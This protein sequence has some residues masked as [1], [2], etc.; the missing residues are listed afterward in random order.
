M[1]DHLEHRLIAAARRRWV[2]CVAVLYTI[3][4]LWIGLVPFDFVIRGPGH[5]PAEWWGLAIA[6]AHAFDLAA[7][8]ALYIPVGLLLRALWR[9][10]V[11]RRIGDLAAAILLG[12]T[13]T[14]ATEW[15][16]RFSP[17][18]VGSV[19]DFACNTVG[20]GVGALLYSLVGLLSFA[21]RRNLRSM[22]RRWSA[23]ILERP[24][25]VAAK[26]LAAIIFLTAMVPFDVTISVNRL[27]QS[28]QSTCWHPFERDA[29]I[30]RVVYEQK[31]PPGV[32]VPPRIRLNRLR[33]KQQLQ[34]DY[35]RL[36][37]AYCLL[38]GLLSV[39]LYRHCAMTGGRAA[40][41]SVWSATLLAM[42]CFAG[43]WVVMSRSSDVTEILLAIIGSSVGTVAGA[44][45]ARRPT[46]NHAK[47]A[48]P[49]S[50]PPDG[51][52]RP[53]T[54][55]WLGAAIA[56]CA[57][58]AIARETVPLTATGWSAD[59]PASPASVEWLPLSGYQ[60]TKL[61]I[62]VHD[63][64]GKLTG[65]ALIFGLWTVRRNVID[66]CGRA[67]RPLRVAAVAMITVAGL[68]ALQLV[69]PTRTPSVTDVLI[70]GAAAATGVMVA[71]V[72]RAAIALI[73]ADR[74]QRGESVLFNVAFS[75]QAPKEPAAA[76]PRRPESSEPPR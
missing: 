66:P 55:R 30:S 58:F 43:Q 64:F 14:Y 13:I 19:A 51:A 50:G 9:R 36:I 40:V 27:A 47:P 57:V 25:L 23:D 53:R 8:V 75:G 69:I 5:Q 12:M 20:T 74:F 1:N 18:R 26:V 46:A 15:F 63:L 3:P 10:H 37:T 62:A 44:V 56:V 7:N 39:Y 33:D 38:G 52:P 67:V 32:P 65:W 73:A 16:Q 34:L 76:T 59:L 31:S 72:G 21:L 60:R 42:V 17:S 41:W 49:S 2:E 4:L 6:P 28:I 22:R 29:R 35:V 61:P 54:V 11:S 24:S 68:E 71:R 48:N 45:Y 70:A